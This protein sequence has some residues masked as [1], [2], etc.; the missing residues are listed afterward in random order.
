[1]VTA[2]VMLETVISNVFITDT[3]FATHSSFLQ[4]NVNSYLYSSSVCD[5]LLNSE[6]LQN[7]TITVIANVII[8]TGRLQT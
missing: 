7:L 4:L 8:L 6:I 3:N 1:M 2:N 5:L